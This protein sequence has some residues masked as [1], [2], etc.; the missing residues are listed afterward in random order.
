[1][2]GSLCLS[3]HKDGGMCLR[4][5]NYVETR[6]AFL[7]FTGKERITMSKELKLEANE[8]LYYIK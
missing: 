5:V 6:Q 8:Y 7:L 2:L 3:R 4:K 1:M